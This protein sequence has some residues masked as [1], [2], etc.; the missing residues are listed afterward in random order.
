MS[1]PKAERKVE[2]SKSNVNLGQSKGIVKEKHKPVK[3]NEL[4]KGKNNSERPVDALVLI[5][6]NGKSL[7]DWLTDNFNS[8]DASAS[9]KS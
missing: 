8:R 2:E 9:K 4:T 5:L 1:W 3:A 6:E 7:T